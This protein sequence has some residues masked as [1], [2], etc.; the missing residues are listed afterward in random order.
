MNT[1]IKSAE[2]SSVPFY[3]IRRA[4]IGSLNNDKILEAISKVLNLDIRNSC[5]VKSIVHTYE[6]KVHIVN[7][8]SKVDVGRSETPGNTLKRTNA[9]T[10]LHYFNYEELKKAASLNKG[11]YRGILYGTIEHHSCD[12]QTSCPK[13]SGTGI[14]KS[15]DG[16]KQIDC[17][18]CH[19]F[20]ECVSCSGTGRYT[21]TNCEGNGLCPECNEGWCTCETCQGDGEVECPDC[22]GTGDFI[23]E[24]CNE[25]GG[26]GYYQWDKK[27]RVCNGTGRFIRKCKR[28]NGTGITKCEYCDGDGGWSCDECNGTGMCSHCKGEGNFECKACSGSGKCGKCKGRG[29]VW[30]PDCHGKG[31]CFD[32]KGEK[33]ITCPRCNGTGEFQT[34][35]EYTFSENEI[36]KQFCT[37]QIDGINDINGD[38]CYQGVIYEFFAGRAAIYQPEEL[39]DKVP[40]EHY[41]LVKKWIELDNN[42]TFA[43]DKL[44]LDYLNTTATLYRVPVSKFILKCNDKVFTILIAG[45][46]KVVYYDDL[47]NFASRVVGRIKNLFQKC[48]K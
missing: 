17:P 35:K 43:K 14:C 36:N 8:T 3:E 25:C 27:C 18:V 6:Y 32:C 22:N 4:A 2:L 41:A 20:K 24:E 9:P 45:Y 23:N 42:S 44:N 30:C 29:K 34:Y 40:Q 21:C 5:S 47:P 19:G 38:E 37:L 13:C 7:K 48:I 39:L 46:N 1:Y 28:C 12:K 16:E 10:K 26:S 31:L 11:K 15:C 33:L